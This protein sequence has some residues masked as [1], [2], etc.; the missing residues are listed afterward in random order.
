MM[1]LKRLRILLLITMLAIIITLT[2]QLTKKTSV[3]PQDD[4]FYKMTIRENQ[5]VLY[6]GES[7]I[8]VYANIVP[9]NLPFDDQIALKKGIYFKTRSDADRAAE[10]YDG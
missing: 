7:F 9:K 1:T 2:Y 8:T 10:D 6:K 5:V 3:I 4:L